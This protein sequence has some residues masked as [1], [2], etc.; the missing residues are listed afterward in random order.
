VFAITDLASNAEDPNLVEPWG[1]AFAPG[2]GVSVANNG[3]STSTQYEGGSVIALGGS[4][5]VI[6]LPSGPAGTQFKP[7]G[8]VTNST[9]DFVVGSGATAGPALLIYAGA[10]GMIAAWAP[11]LGSSTATTSYSDS[12]GAVYTG[13]TLANNGSGNFLYAADFRGKK[14]DVFDAAF[15]KQPT[16]AGHFSFADPTLATT[17]APFGIQ[18]LNDGKDGG[19]QLYVTYA[20]PQGAASVPTAGKG[21]GFVNVFDANG[22][23][24]QH[25]IVGGPLNAPWGLALAPA[26]F[27]TFAQT[28]LVANFGDGKINAFDLTT[29]HFSGALSDI[30]HNDLS[31][32][33]LMG[34]AFGNDVANQA[35]NALFFAAG[36]GSSTTG[37]YGRIDVARPIA[38]TG[39]RFQNPCLGSPWPGC[40]PNGVNIRPYV[41]HQLPIGEMLVSVNGHLIATETGT[42]LVHWDPP[43]GTS[44]VTVTVIDT[45]GNAATLSVTY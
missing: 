24:V 21:L 26:D 37:V 20:L 9:A 44:E 8:I 31:V 4:P 5:Q 41:A 6:S 13:L 18:A 45:A 12:T 34:I 3:T 33:G 22:D 19:A 16:A 29:G 43:Q 36:S 42:G 35:H 23:L 38:V 25:L 11:A 17:Y 15:K 32:S 40:V 30:S 1:I 27:G 39:I 2:S 28:L 14:I 10:S 7:T